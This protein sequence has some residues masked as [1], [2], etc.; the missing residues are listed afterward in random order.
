MTQRFVDGIGLLLNKYSLMQ[1]L[2]ANRFIFL[3]GHKKDYRTALIYSKK[4]GYVLNQ[5][6][7]YL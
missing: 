1:L 7:Q 6:I 5:E 2:I 3:K 4:L